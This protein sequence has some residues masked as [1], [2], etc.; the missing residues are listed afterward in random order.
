MN[1]NC[2]GLQLLVELVTKFRLVAFAILQYL[3]GHTNKAFFVGGGGVVV[4]A[5][6]KQNKSV[7]GG[8]E[9]NFLSEYGYSTG[10]P[11]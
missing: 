6:Q 7:E 4:V 2:N 8:K 11:N 3:Y 1:E 10:C 5:C 9:Y